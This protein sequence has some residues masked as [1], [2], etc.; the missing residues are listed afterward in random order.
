M[1]K[2]QKNIQRVVD[3]D[4]F[5]N[6]MKKY[7]IHRKVPKY[8]FLNLYVKCEFTHKK[9]IFKQKLTVLAACY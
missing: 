6:E 4:K 7:L 9:K 2:Y 3:H 5:Q 1:K 8:T